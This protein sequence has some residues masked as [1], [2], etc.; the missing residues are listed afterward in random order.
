MKLYVISDL[1]TDVCRF[2]FT[3][4]D[5]MPDYDVA[6]IAG[7]VCEDMVK[8]VKWLGASPLRGKPII[9]VAGNHEF[10]GEKMDTN[11]VKAAKIANDHGV[12]ILQ[13]SHVDIDGVRFIGATLWTDFRL[14][15]DA[16]Q[17]PAMWTAE[18]NMNDYRR[19]RLAQ[20]NYRV[21]RAKDTLAEFT[22]S[23]DYIERTLLQTAHPAVVVTHHGPSLRSVNTERYGNTL[24]NAAYCSDMEHI[25]QKATLWIHGHT[26]F[27]TQYQIGDCRVVSNCRGYE[28][29]E[30]TGYDPE[31]VVE[32]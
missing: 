23:R 8:A 28:G 12:T 26:H 3:F 10:Y 24:L 7:D 30:N 6:V 13:D 21:L 17:L 5:P 1:H 16:H 29:Y 14:A 22:T 25:A 18:E 4:P 20:H 31:L 11:R 19:I 32:V 9:Y 27:C 15:G 2:K